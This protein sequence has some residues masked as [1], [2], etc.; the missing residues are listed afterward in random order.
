M[1]VCVLSNE[2]NFHSLAHTTFNRQYPHLELTSSRHMAL[3]CAE[4]AALSSVDAAAAAVPA[5]HTNRTAALHMLL[6]L[7]HHWSRLR[8]TGVWR[9][10]RR[11]PPRGA[12]FVR[13]PAAPL[14]GPRAGPPC[15]PQKGKG[16]GIIRLEPGVQLCKAGSAGAA[17]LFCR[18]ARYCMVAKRG[19]QGL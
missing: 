12:A 10:G 2:I 6:S 1:C 11:Q 4:R 5:T 7:H 18:P 8:L 16:C 3:H 17:L 14:E 19:K 15:R 13:G 9:A